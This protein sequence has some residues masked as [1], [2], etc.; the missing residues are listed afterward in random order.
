[1]LIFNGN[2]GVA[3]VNK[4]VE[5]LENNWLNSCYEESRFYDSII[6]QLHG[7]L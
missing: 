5:L 2:G 4:V 3:C 1:M 6:E 7:T